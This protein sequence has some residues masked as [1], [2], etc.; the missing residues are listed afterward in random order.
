MSFHH[1]TN[2]AYWSWLKLAL[3]CPQVVLTGA[4][5]EGLPL[6]IGKR[7]LDVVQNYSGF[8]CLFMRASP[9]HSTQTRLGQSVCKVSSSLPHDQIFL[10][11]LCK[12]IRGFLRSLE[13][14]KTDTMGHKHK[15][16]SGANEAHKS[17]GDTFLFSCQRKSWLVPKIKS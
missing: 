8:M 3:Q 12:S 11:V 13:N 17:G 5:I 14:R 4:V 16:I 6:L 1:N 10:K 9:L 2:L 15:P 7:K